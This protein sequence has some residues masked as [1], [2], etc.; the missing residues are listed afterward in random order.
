MSMF[1]ILPRQTLTTLAPT[2]RK[3]FRI[4]LSHDIPS[5]DNISLFQRKTTKIIYYNFELPNYFTDNIVAN[6]L[7][8][9][10]WSA[11]KFKYKYSGKIQKFINKKKVFIMNKYKV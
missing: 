9:E 5:S 7:P 2:E 11:G 4:F 1:K 6:N 3:A 10:S 8:I